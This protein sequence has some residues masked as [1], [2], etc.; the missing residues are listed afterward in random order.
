[1]I[2]VGGLLVT[3]ALG[4]GGRLL[5]LIR[6]DPRPPGVGSPTWSPDG[7]KIAFIF[8]F[9]GELR[10]MNADGSSPRTVLGDAGNP[11][12]SPDWQRIAFQSSPSREDKPGIAVVNA[13]GS[14]R[15]LLSAEPSAH[16]PAW[17]PDGTQIAFISWRERGPAIRTSTS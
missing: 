8:G 1:M 12:W 14:G 5:D 9:P 2:L 17:S 15:R 7:R 6:D 11:V 13:D 3:P 10:V 4:I 16:L